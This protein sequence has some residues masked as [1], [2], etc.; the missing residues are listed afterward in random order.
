MQISETETESE[1]SFGSLVKSSFTLQFEWAARNSAS[2]LPL[3]VWSLISEGALCLRACFALWRRTFWLFLWK[4]YRLSRCSSGC[5]FSSSDRK[6][7]TGQ[8]IAAAA[9]GDG[10]DDVL[11]LSRP[12]SLLSSRPHLSQRSASGFPSV[13]PKLHWFWPLYLRGP[14]PLALAVTLRWQKN[15]ESWQRRCSRTHKARS[16]CRQSVLFLGYCFVTV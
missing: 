12:P 14:G 4:S 16:F 6:E 1:C 3:F 7:E 10:G 15:T 9:V 5:F 8:S 11:M 13:F 2:L